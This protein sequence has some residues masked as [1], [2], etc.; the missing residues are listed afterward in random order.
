MIATNRAESQAN[1]HSH[2]IAFADAHLLAGLCTQ[3]ERNPEP[4]WAL[5]GLHTEAGIG[6]V[7]SIGDFGAGADLVTWRKCLGRSALSYASIAVGV[8]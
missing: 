2:S 8:I 7:D 5:F 1:G 4:S 3:P 6:Y